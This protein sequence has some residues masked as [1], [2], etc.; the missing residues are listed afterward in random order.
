M[1]IFVILLCDLMMSSLISFFPALFFAYKEQKVEEEYRMKFNKWEISRN[2]KVRTIKNDIIPNINSN[3]SMISKPLYETTTLLD[4]YY[5]LNI[6]LPKCRNLDSIQRLWKCVKLM[7]LFE[8]YNILEMEGRL[9]KI[10]DRLDS[11]SS[12]IGMQYNPLQ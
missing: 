1:A 5:I 6:L 3:I 11:I 12:I 8:A 9:D 10:I 7:G 4:Q 2:D